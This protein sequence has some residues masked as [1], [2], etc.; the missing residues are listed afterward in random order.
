MKTF[1]SKPISSIFTRKHNCPCLCHLRIWRHDIPVRSILAHCPSLQDKSQYL[2]K[3]FIIIFPHSSSFSISSAWVLIRL[4]TW[5][6]FLTL[7]GKALG[8][9]DIVEGSPRRSSFLRFECNILFLDCNK[10]SL[11]LGVVVEDD[12]VNAPLARTTGML[13]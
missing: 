4:G 2:P 12:G 9:G 1:I 3:T 7:A 10:L 5:N 13:A 11:C 8:I 6:A